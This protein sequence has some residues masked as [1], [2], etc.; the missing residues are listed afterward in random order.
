M[1]SFLWGISP[2]CLADEVKRSAYLYDYCR[3]RAGRI[4][5]F[6]P[7]WGKVWRRAIGSAFSIFVY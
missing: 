6:A 3:V 4:L 2:S 7:T 5:V 1:S